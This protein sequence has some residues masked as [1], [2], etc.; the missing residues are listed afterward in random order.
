MARPDAQ[1]PPAV[2]VR[3]RAPFHLA[4]PRIRR[5]AAAALLLG[6]KVWWPTASDCPVSHQPSPAR[7]GFGSQRPTASLAPRA[8]PGRRVSTRPDIALEV[9]LGKWQELPLRAAHTV[10]LTRALPERRRHHRHARDR[11]PGTLGAL[12]RDRR[13]P[14]PVGPPRAGQAQG[15]LGKPPRTAA[16]PGIRSAM[17]W[18]A[19]R[20]TRRP[21]RMR[22]RCGASR[23]GR[24]SQGATCTAPDGCGASRRYGSPPTRARRW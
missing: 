15:G 8:S 11:P 24:R 10:G 2:S 4:R 22:R 5:P 17:G 14:P 21:G 7:R 19:Q 12:R 1:G 16:C 18:L 13:D 6:Q 23:R 3:S 9:T 20:R